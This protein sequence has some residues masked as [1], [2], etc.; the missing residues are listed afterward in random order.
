M[1]NMANSLKSLD[2]LL[3]CPTTR[4]P[5]QRNGDFLVSRE[6]VRYPVVHGV[7]VLLAPKKESTLWVRE[8]SFHSA[9]ENPTDEFHLETIGIAKQDLSELKCRLEKHRLNPEPVDPVASFLVAATSGYM[10]LDQVGK[11]QTI[12]IPKIRLPIGNGKLLLDIG[13]SW[14][15]WSL[16][17]AQAGY[18]VIGIDPSLG[19]VLAAQ[20]QARLMG[21]NAQFIVADALQLPFAEDIFDT[22]FSYS[23]MQHFS[24]ENAEAAIRQAATVAKTDANLLIQMPNKFG[25]RSLF[26][27][28]KRRSRELI[29]FDV[30]YYSP[31]ALREVFSRNFGPAR[32]SV[33]GFFG[34]GIQPSDRPTLPFSKKIIIDA[35]ELL[36]V[37]STVIMPLTNCA[38]SVYVHAQNRKAAELTRKK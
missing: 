3:C 16:A 12:P 32:L 11:L 37:F 7:P 13:C 29:G 18:R 19:A 23:V 4:S 1:T 21:L 33:D 30:R 9:K 10:Y 28:W 35:S 2:N 5:L 25:I 15:R 38:D 6:G 17:A 8:A 26:H 31:H 14:G 24:T 34:L 20:R 36:R 27:Q 22:I